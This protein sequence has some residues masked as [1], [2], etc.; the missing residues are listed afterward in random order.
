MRV[1]KPTGL[2]SPRTCQA[3]KRGDGGR[4]RSADDP[5]LSPPGAARQGVEGWREAC[6][7]RLSPPGAVRPCVEGWREEEARNRARK[8][9]EPRTHTEISPGMARQSGRGG[10]A[11]EAGADAAGGRPVGLSA[12]AASCVG[13]PR[14]H[15][16]FPPGMARRPT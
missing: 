1:E 15:T 4:G 6:E 8:K 14:I 13:W 2:L 5:R 9:E 11:A 7:L 16:L 3:V 12:A 10:G